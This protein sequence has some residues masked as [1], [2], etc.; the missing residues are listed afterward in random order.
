[1]AA[2][3][4]CHHNAVVDARESIECVLAMLLAWPGTRMAGRHHNAG[5]DARQ[6]IES[7]LLLEQFSES[8]LTCTT[9]T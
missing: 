3:K 8:N 7:V 6:S 2:P 1:V 9:A 5:V 4:G